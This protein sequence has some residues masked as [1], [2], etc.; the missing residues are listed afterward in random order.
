[1]GGDTGADTDTGEDTGG[2]GDTVVVD[3]WYEEGR[4]TVTWYVETDGAASWAEIWLIDTGDP[5]FEGPCRADD[6]GS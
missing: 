6:I 1:M 5:A 4:S 2:S 3:A